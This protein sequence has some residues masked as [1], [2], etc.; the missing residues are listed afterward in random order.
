MDT[1][2]TESESRREANETERNTSNTSDAELSIKLV[3]EIFTNMFKEQEEKQFLHFFIG[4]RIK[5]TY[6]YAYQF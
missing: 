3:K 4:F 2:N 5:T 6:P 1:R